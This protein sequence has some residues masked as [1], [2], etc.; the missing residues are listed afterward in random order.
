M[1]HAKQTKTF[2]VQKQIRKLKDKVVSINNKVQEEQLEL[3][4][5]LPLDL[6]VQQAIRQ[7]G[8]Y[9]ANPNYGIDVDADADVVVPKTTAD[10]NDLYSSIVSTIL[11]HKR[12]QSAL[13][14]WNA[15]VTEHRRWRLS[16]ND[17]KEYG[18]GKREF[19][20]AKR[21]KAPKSVQAATTTTSMFCNLNGDEEEDNNNNNELVMSPYGPGAHL[22]DEPVRK[23]RKGQRARRAKAQALQAKKEG[24]RRDYKSLNWRAEKKDDERKPSSKRSNHST[25]SAAPQKKEEAPEPQ[26]PSWAAKQQ[27]KTGIVAFQGTKITF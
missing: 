5:D 1:K 2:L 4:K 20:G 13:E 19:G 15:K 18:G 16:I 27:Q 7:L 6:V 8:L 17:K 11:Q 26:H 12:M 21:P 22:P 24:R 14:E 9:H 23:N 3:L 10:D 25:T